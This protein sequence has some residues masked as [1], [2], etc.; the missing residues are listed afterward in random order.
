MSRNKPDALRYNNAILE[1][2]EG[3][4][5]VDKYKVAARSA[6]TE[7]AIYVLLN[8]DALDQAG[9]LKLA[10]KYAL[11]EGDFPLISL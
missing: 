6:L 2:C 4:L 3:L 8:D 1:A 7:A 11:K 9:R 5:A 10:E